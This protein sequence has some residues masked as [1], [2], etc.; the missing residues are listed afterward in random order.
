MAAFSL[1][2]MATVSNTTFVAASDCLA[3]Y[4][5]YSYLP[6]AQ[7]LATLS[8][9]IFVFVSPLSYYVTTYYGAKVALVMGSIFLIIGNWVRVAA[10]RS[11]YINIGMLLAGHGCASIGQPFALTVATHY[12]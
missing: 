12:R 4:L 11:D 10:V 7:W 1:N 3:A 9:L 2:F 6:G 8:M 5:P